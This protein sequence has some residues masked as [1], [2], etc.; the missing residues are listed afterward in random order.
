MIPG[1]SSKEDIMPSTGLSLHNKAWS[2]HVNSY[3]VLC[4]LLGLP[5]LIVEL[6]SYFIIKFLF[7]YQKFQ[8]S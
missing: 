2:S 1:I 5:G 6:V 3:Y 7:E 4:F 8:L